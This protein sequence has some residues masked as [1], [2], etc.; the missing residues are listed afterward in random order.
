MRYILRVE[1]DSFTDKVLECEL[2]L[3]GSEPID[4]AI[5]VFKDAMIV[6]ADAI[7][8][9]EGRSFSSSQRVDGRL[10]EHEIAA[11][12]KVFGT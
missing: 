6:C 1:D 2:P 5:E 10:S 12:K 7:M 9:K 11:Y 8:K 3:D 4:K